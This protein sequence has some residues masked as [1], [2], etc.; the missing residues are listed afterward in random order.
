MSSLCSVNMGGPRVIK[1]QKRDGVK[2][3]RTVQIRMAAKRD[4]NGAAF[5]YSPRAWLKLAWVKWLGGAE[6]E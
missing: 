4:L 2:V 3:H 1:N 6:L 5:S